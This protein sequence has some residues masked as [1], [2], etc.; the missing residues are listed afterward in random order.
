M[1]I[2]N[3]QHQ[4]SILLLIL[5]LFLAAC[6]TL[7]V[8]M[9]RDE[10]TSAPGAATPQ[11]RATQQVTNPPQE[12]VD[13][14][15]SPT[16]AV[17]ATILPTST[18][19]ISGNEPVVEP[20]A[21]DV[22]S[23]LWATYRDLDS[24]FGY[25][26]PCHWINRDTTLMSYDEFFFMNRSVRGHWAD[27]D[28]PAGAVKL[29][30]AA[31]DYADSGIEPGTPLEQAVPQAIADTIVST[32][33]V[34]FGTKE[35][36]R[37]E[38]EGTVYP[39]DQTNEIY[40]FQIS[41]ES[42]LLL[43]V[44]PRGAL[45]SPDVQGVVNSLALTA[46]EEI[47]I[48]EADP[49]GPLEGRQIYF[50]DEAGYCFQYPADYTLEAFPPSGFP[51]LGDIATLKLER[52]FYTLGLTSTAWRVG[53]GSTLDELVTDFL[54]G[55]PDDSASEVERNPIDRVGGVDFIIGREPAEFLERMPGADGSRDIFAKHEDRLYRISFVPSIRIN[56]Q[57]ESDVEAL[58]LVVTST[59]SFLPQ[60]N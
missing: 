18:A 32:E 19:G 31:F 15:P 37:V 30:I 16:A 28:P 48:P 49:G 50:D 57:A 23:P 24:G 3:E 55:L 29:E 1:S 44:S 51:Y 59:F 12:V 9:E 4:R 6:G 20:P 60:D 11:A 13:P 56:P 52:P 45:S 46:G 47:A 27:G 34:T 41:P 54:G 53:E 2:R 21:E 8:G 22:A 58:F 40:F 14:A 10:P 35:A 17:R 38:L 25:A 26:F 7:E 5:A 39:G 33:R 43:S 36:L 42:M